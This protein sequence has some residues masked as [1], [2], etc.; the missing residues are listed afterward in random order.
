MKSCVIWGAAGHAKVARSILEANGYTIVGI[1]DN[2]VSVSPFD[3]VTFFGGWADFERL[4]EQFCNA[5]FVVAIGGEHGRTRVSISV[6]LVAAGLSP[7]LL[8]HDS[9][10]IAH[11]AHLGDGCQILAMSAVCEEVKIEPFTIV[12]TSATVDHECRIGRGVHIMPGATLAGCV[13]VEDFA[14]VGSNATI[15]P[16]LRIGSG[17]FVGAGAVVTRDVPTGAIVAGSPA[18]IIKRRPPHAS[19]MKI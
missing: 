14:T 15:L 17:A 7:V 19:G 4:R 1:F 16:R 9:S 5:R 12:N 2:F 11:N 6:N 13:I 18:R 8:K 10:H 3:D